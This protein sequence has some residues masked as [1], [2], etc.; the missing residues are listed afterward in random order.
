V[1]ALDGLTVVE[2]GGGVA[3]AYATKLLA[4]LGAAVGKVDPG[5]PDGLGAYLDSPLVGSSTQLPP[6]PREAVP[7]ML[8]SR[9]STLSDS[10]KSTKMLAV[11]VPS[12]GSSTIVAPGGSG[13]SGPTAAMREPSI[14]TRTRGA[15]RSE[16]PVAGQPKRQFSNFGRRSILLASPM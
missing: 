4:D 1:G 5:R 12:P 8:N 11:S 6:V 3:A 10:V 13:T 16:R 2:L 7:E 9:I 15:A 14:R